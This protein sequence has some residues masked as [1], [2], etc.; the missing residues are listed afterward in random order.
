MRVFIVKDVTGAIAGVFEAVD[1]ALDRA[2]NE[3]E[4]P[5]YNDG[6]MESY[7]RERVKQDLLTAECGFCV[8]VSVD[9]EDCAVPAAS[10]ESWL[11]S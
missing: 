8:G 3:V 6:G 11:V 4:Y 10:V 2:E 9:E 5:D 7:S 1:H